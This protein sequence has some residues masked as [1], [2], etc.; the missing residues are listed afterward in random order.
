M[1]FVCAVISYV[2]G[3]TW[4][5]TR[6]QLSKLIT[7][8]ITLFIIILL[9]F[10]SYNIYKESVKKKLSDRYNKIIIEYQGIDKSIVISSMK[11]IIN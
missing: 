2:A 3:R 7:S 1:K 8:I 6:G 10:Y 5:K 11:E 9:S 4:L